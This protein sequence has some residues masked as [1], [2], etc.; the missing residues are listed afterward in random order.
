[1][2]QRNVKILQAKKLLIF[3][4]T[5]NLV[6]D[7]II[8]WLSKNGLQKCEWYDFN[9]ERKSQ[10]YTEKDGEY[11]CFNARGQVVACSSYWILDRVYFVTSIICSCVYFIPIIGYI[12]LGYLIMTKLKQ[13]DLIN[14]RSAKLRVIFPIIM[15]EFVLVTRFVIFFYS[16]F[17]LD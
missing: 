7:I 1:M 5:L 2:Q 9:V 16:K 3:F 12:P 10:C 17:Y 13:V 15:I 14:Y 8:F 11:T 6:L 4:V